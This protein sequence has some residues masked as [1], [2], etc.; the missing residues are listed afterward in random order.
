VT[1]YLYD[2]ILCGYPTKHPSRTC[3]AH[4]DFTPPIPGLDEPYPDALESDADALVAPDR[5]AGHP[6]LRRKQAPLDGGG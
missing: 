2:C 6:A 5:P 1:A 4:R 3:I